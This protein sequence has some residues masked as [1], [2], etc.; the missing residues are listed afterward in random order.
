MNSYQIEYFLNAAK[1][2]NFTKAAEELHTSQPTVSRQIAL[3]EEELGIPLFVRDKG[4]VRLTVGGA[5]M[6]QEFRKIKKDLNAAVGS[7]TQVSKGLEGKISI[8]YLSGLN[9]DIF[10]Y[11][12]LS[13]F[14]KLYPLI[15][16]KIESATFSVL[17]EKLANGSY[18]IIYTYS[19]ELAAFE[20]I[21]Y[22]KVYE[23]TPMF[24]IS[25]SHPLAMK[26]RCVFSDLG[27]QTFLLPSPEESPGRAAEMLSICGSL[28]IKNIF[29]KS[30]D[31]IESML[32]GIR[33]NMGVGFL[34][35][36]MDCIFDSRYNCI[37]IPKNTQDVYIA[38][39]WNA[40]NINSVIPLYMTTFCEYKNAV[41]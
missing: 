38:A 12:P 35:S 8:G 26:N 7:V 5:I 28:G 32:F 22:E 18:D 36:A 19:F 15:D 6:F 16:L 13:E 4:T 14:S 29:I 27:E 31:T 39:V 1:H 24:V 25:K 41:P 9:T 3:L 34:S 2:L 21:F 10:I 11:P 17:R 33:Y 37:Q 20:N 23:V 30:M 40:N